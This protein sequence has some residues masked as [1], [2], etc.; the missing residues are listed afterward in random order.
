[1]LMSEDDHRLWSWPGNLEIGF[2]KRCI[3]QIV[4]LINIVRILQEALAHPLQ[5]LSQLDKIAH[6]GA[7]PCNHQVWGIPEPKVSMLDIELQDVGYPCHLLETLLH[8]LM[9]PNLS[10]PLFWVITKA[11]FP[12]LAV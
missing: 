12:H 8:R 2:L 9:V 6:D 1:M 11:D 4:R 10:A 3:D 7:L 5:L